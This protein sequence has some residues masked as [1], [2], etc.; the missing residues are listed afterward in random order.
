[1]TTSAKQRYAEL[2]TEVLLKRSLAGGA[3]SDE[4]ESQWIE[5][6]EAC[7]WAMTP[8]EQDDTEAEYESG[9]LLK[10]EDP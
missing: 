9:G 8:E 6:L 4:E 2:L 7:W 10:E 1:M 3:L 5:K